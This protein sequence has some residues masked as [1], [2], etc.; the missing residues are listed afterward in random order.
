MGI[1]DLL[2]DKIYIFSIYLLHIDTHWSN[3]HNWIGPIHGIAGC[4]RTAYF[5]IYQ[6]KY[7]HNSKFLYIGLCTRKIMHACVFVASDSRWRLSSNKCV[8]PIHP[9]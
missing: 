6:P 1:V 3:S 4:T 7:Q 2:T 9:D 8:G 5:Q